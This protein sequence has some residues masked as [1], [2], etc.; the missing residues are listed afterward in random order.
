VRVNG[1][2]CSIACDA[3]GAI[4]ARSGGRRLAAQGARHFVA[5]MWT[6]AP[7]IMSTASARAGGGGRGRR[8]A[9]GAGA[10]IHK[11]CFRQFTAVAGTVRG[12]RIVGARRD[13]GAVAK[14][15]RPL[16]SSSA[17]PGGVRELVDAAIAMDASRSTPRKHHL[18]PKSY[19]RRWEESG[20]LRVTEID[21]GNS[22]QTSAAK[23]ARE[24]DYYRFESHD[25]D[26]VEFPP[27]IIEALLGA[28]EAPAV[29]AIDSMLEARGRRPDPA[30]AAV[31][32]QFLGCQLTRG[33]SFRAQMRELVQKAHVLQYGR[34]TAAGIRHMLEKRAGASVDDAAVQEAVRFLDD[35]E[36]GDV[37]I[38]P[39]DAWIMGMALQYAEL[40]GLVLTAREWR[41]IET[42]RNLVTCDEP[43]VL[44]G[45]PGISR[46]EQGGIAT[47]G[48]IVFPLA[49]DA[50]LAMFREDVAPIGAEPA[51]N[52]LEAAD[53]NREILANASRWG[54]ERPGR[55]ATLGLRVPAFRERVRFD[56]G[57]G[58]SSDLPGAELVRI[59]KPSR[60]A[61][62]P[63]RPWPVERWWTWATGSADDRRRS[64]AAGEVA[65]GKA[66]AA[67]EAY[68][69][70]WPG[71]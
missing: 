43:V 41:V 14:E 44:I 56:D 30:A 66:R 68:G 7:A 33:H 54:F 59:H 63:S 49:P 2:A 38:R 19:L 25:I 70:K 10:L 20:Q 60:W 48:V 34:M 61:A 27:M 26:P 36:A 50:L 47:A 11:S 42:P 58:L 45:G 13:T 53:I 24:T 1:R 67:L 4:D 31:V 29:K 15:A 6:A 9:G 16:G 12:T 17:L 35:L 57:L 71:D 28:I 55:R 5:L 18:V 46:A 23:A 21:T 65:M 8:C 40:V 32:A 69:G 22:Y 51:L 3:E 64:H 39:Q 62:E 37:V 52:L